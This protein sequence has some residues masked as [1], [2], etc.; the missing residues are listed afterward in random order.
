[1]AETTER[2]VSRWDP[3]AELA[4]FGDFPSFRSRLGRLLEGSLGEEIGPSIVPAPAVDITESDGEYAITAEIPGVDKDDLTIEL[5]DG[6]LTIRGEKKSQREE[7]REKARLLERSYGA[8]SR[9]FSLPSDADPDKV[10]ASFS[11]GVLTIKVL[12]RP[13]A[14]P[15]QVAI[16]A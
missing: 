5:Q 15:K 2:R 16:K 8:F 1:M 6:V 9:S 12:K 11:D 13:E 4:S 14:K 7:K 10:E 3:F